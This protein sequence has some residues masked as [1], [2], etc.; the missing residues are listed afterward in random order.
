MCVASISARVRAGR[1]TMS[2]ILYVRPRKTVYTSII[3]NNKLTQ[4]FS[5]I[6]VRRSRKLRA[7]CVYTFGKYSVECEPNARREAYVVVKDPVRNGRDPNQL[8]AIPSEF[9]TS[10]QVLAT[11][12]DT[13][14]V[15]HE[16]AGDRDT[17]DED[18]GGL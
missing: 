15:P 13:A 11:W 3:H 14:A 6:A 4:G 12:E 17:L 10:E 8:S 7:K 5:S 1:G 18:M 2:E 16:E 9:Y